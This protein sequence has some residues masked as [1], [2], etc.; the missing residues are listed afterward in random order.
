MSGHRF[1]EMPPLLAALVLGLS[2][3]TTATLPAGPV[4]PPPQAQ[5]STPWPERSD[6]GRASPTSPAAAA[7]PE[8]APLWRQRK[9]S[10]SEVRRAAEARVFFGHQS[11]GGNVMK[12]ITALFR[13][14]GGGRPR[15]IDITGGNAF[16]PRSDT[17][18]IAHAFVGRNGRPL[19]KIADFDSILRGGAAKRIDVALLKLCY[20]DVKANTDVEEVFHRYRAVLLALEEDY[21]E[22]TFLYSTVPLKTEAPAD[23]AARA[24][25][26][27]LIRDEYG[28]SGRLYD[29]AAVESTTLDGDRISGTYEGESY[30]A[31]F[32]GFS[33]DGG[34][35]NEAGATVAATALL[36]QIARVT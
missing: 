24:R 10:S 32:P 5:V 14:N 31:L 36:K 25:L 15:Y 22:V 4:A 8:T 26:N 11:V 9:I 20:A 17:G 1:F 2:A 34:H 13:V 23:N 21:P 19:E 12:G 33:T 18:Y 7:T 16:L 6:D 29:I 27:K 35:L 3:C 30:D 28:E